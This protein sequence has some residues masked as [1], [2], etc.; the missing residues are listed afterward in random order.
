MIVTCESFIEGVAHSKSFS[1]WIIV[2]ISRFGRPEL[3]LNKDKI[4]YCCHVI[5]K[6]KKSYEMLV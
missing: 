3:K 4:K 6:I 2:E 5:K 1:I